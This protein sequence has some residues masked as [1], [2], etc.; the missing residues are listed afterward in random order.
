MKLKVIEIIVKGQQCYLV[1]PSIFGNPSTTTELLQ[2]HNYLGDEEALKHD[3]DVLRLEGDGWYAK[4]G[5]FIDALPQVVEIEI[6]AVEISR[7]VGR[8]RHEKLNL[9]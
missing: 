9:A 6:Q 5:L 2:A 1:D 4:S 3:L 8:E 7:R